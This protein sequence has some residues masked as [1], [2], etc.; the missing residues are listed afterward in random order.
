MAH[1]PLAIQIVDGYAPILPQHLPHLVG[2]IKVARCRHMSAALEWP[3]LDTMLLPASPLL[4]QSISHYHRH[5]HV[6]AKLASSPARA[7]SRERMRFMI[8]PSSTISP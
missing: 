5:M 4:K 1:A 3:C 2:S 6:K 7:S 8:M